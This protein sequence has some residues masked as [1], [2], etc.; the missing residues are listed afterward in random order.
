MRVPIYNGSK[1]RKSGV[2]LLGAVARLT[3]SNYLL[4]KIT[5]C[6]I[7][8]TASLRRKRNHV[9]CRNDE[10][11]EIQVFFLKSRIVGSDARSIRHSGLRMG[12]GV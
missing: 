1:G 8:A 12:D 6:V 11:V 7:K 4:E 10:V 5:E 9:S 3:R 2:R